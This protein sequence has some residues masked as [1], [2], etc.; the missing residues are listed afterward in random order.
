MPYNASIKIGTDVRQ[1]KLERLGDSITGRQSSLWAGPVNR[2]CA[3]N[4][5]QVE[6]PKPDGRRSAQ[7]ST[8]DLI[9]FGVVAV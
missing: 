4:V 5:R 7:T 6:V 3:A 9:D 2:V 8:E 1:G